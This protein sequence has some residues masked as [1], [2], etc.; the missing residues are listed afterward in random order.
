MMR[1]QT[2]EWHNARLGHAT[3]S[4]VADIV[5]RTKSGYST[6]RANYAAELACERLTGRSCDSYA[7]AAMQ[8]GL[9]K[10]AEARQLY[11]FT[12][13]EPVTR[14]GFLNHPSIARAGASPDGLVG[15][16]GLVEIKCPLTATHIETLIGR[17]PPGR[18]LTQ[19]QWQMAVTERAWCDFVSYDPRLPTGLQLFVQRTQ[20]DEARIGE[21]EREVRLFLSEV[22]ELVRELRRRGGV[23]TLVKACPLDS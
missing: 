21:L 16:A 15:G 13:D 6:S 9:A 5:A 18:Y 19:M 23:A 12:Y 4:R 3:A 7:S 8:W 17:G 20:R 11:E 22:E 14:V 2:S 1:Q 10:E